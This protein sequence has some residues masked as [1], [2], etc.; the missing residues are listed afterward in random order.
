MFSNPCYKLV[1][2]N[3][4][5]LKKKTIRRQAPEGEDFKSIK[6]VLKELKEH[7]VPVAVH[8]FINMVG[9]FTGDNGKLF[10]TDI[11]IMYVLRFYSCR[12]SFVYGYNY[13][14]CHYLN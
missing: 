10:L 7:N 4:E 12:L 14:F 9:A 8:D 5:D 11:F 1:A 2:I 6:A 3:W 13:N